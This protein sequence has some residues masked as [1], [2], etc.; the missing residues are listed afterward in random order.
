VSRDGIHF[1][2]THEFFTLSA[3]YEPV[4]ARDSVRVSDDEGLFHL[5]VTTSLIEAGQA[6]R[7]CLAHLTS[8]DL[9]TW[10]QQAPF[11]IGE[12]EDQ[13]ECSD[14]FHFKRLVLS[15]FQQLRLGTLPDFADAVRPL[16]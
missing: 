16:D 9:Q 5:L 8:V 4:S 7:G 14:Y 3:P 1:E 2:K 10:E 11:I 15:D 13:P 6:T 12:N